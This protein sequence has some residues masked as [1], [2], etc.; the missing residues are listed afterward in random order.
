M[1]SDRSLRPDRGGR[2]LVCLIRNADNELWYSLNH[3]DGA[4]SAGEQFISNDW[5]AVKVTPP[6]VLR[7]TVSPAPVTSTHRGQPLPTQRYRY[8]HR[9]PERYPNAEAALPVGRRLAYPLL[10][11]PEGPKGPRRNCGAQALGK[12]AFASTK[13][14]ERV[15]S[16][17]A[18]PAVHRRI[19][20]E[21]G[22]GGR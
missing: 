7:D 20:S 10:P 3:R 1:A 5:Y 18:L 11:R 6:A 15:I 14:Q 17:A 2:P 16:T 21:Y 19:L 9:T 8:S 4:T 12:E 22:T 13:G